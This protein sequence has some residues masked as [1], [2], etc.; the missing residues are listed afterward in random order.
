MTSPFQIGGT[1][2]VDTTKADS[3]REFKLGHVAT[4][5]TVA[6]IVTSKQMRT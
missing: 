5:M 3:T 2:G 6:F 4:L 1:L